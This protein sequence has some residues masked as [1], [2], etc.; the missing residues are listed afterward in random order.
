MLQSRLSPPSAILVLRP[1]VHSV[2]LVLHFVHCQ[3]HSLHFL[4]A[5]SLV[6]QLPDPESHIPAPPILR[7]PKLS[8][9]LTQLACP[10]AVHV[11][12]SLYLCLYLYLCPSIVLPPHLCGCGPLNF[13]LSCCTSSRSVHCKILAPKSTMFVTVKQNAANCR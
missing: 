4:F 1:S 8:A 11:C 13:S 2:K 7:R 3:W 5:P 10:A 12:L 9:A 6:S